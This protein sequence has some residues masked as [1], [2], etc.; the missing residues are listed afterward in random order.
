[1]KTA[2]SGDFVGRRREL[3]A[4]EA[5]YAA[6]SAQLLPVY[7][8]R[9]VGKT[10]LLRRFA[11]GKP[12][13]FFSAAQKLR[14]SQLS[15]FLRA[16]A[17]HLGQSFLAELRTD[18]WETALRAVRGAADRA[19]KLVLV[20]DEF[21][22]LCASAPELPSVLQ[23][24]WD[25]EWQRDPRL[26]LVL[27][28]SA[29]GFMEREVLGA[30]SPLFGRRTGQMRIEPLGFAEAGEMFPRWSLEE[31]ARLWFVVGGVPAYLRQF[32]AAES[33]AQNLARLVF[34]P[35]GFF[36]QEPAFLLRE[37]LTEPSHAFSILQAVGLGRQG[38][39]E[40]ADE[41]G[42]KPNA[43]DRHLKALVALGY[44]ERVQPLQPGE[45]SRKAVQYRV[46]DPLL[47]FWF[48]YVEAHQHEIGRLAPARAFEQIVAPTWEAHCGDGFERLCRDALPAIYAREGVPG[49]FRV[50]DFW[51]RD[52]QIDVV[53]LRTDGVVDLG[54]CKW[55]EHAGLAAAARE[56]AAAAK[57]YPAGKLRVRPLIF[58]RKPARA[59]P[60]AGAK[61][62]SL[63]EICGD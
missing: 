21:Q 51:S 37:E 46:A 16:A 39:K 35:D 14:Q 30:K 56:L 9:R 49:R 22:W 12:A 36:Q 2:S 10:E 34:R 52:V 47:R 18:S 6:R 54:E 31:R 20:L 32:D 33:V 60:P 63:V 17:S 61:V 25:E 13:V 19:R 43:L 59:K 23:R 1:M 62:Y 45:P 28:G 44:M 5:A 48:R 38:Q 29:I 40:V 7:G 11:A 26:M 50:G 53:G 3:A 57:H 8:R 55:G 24:L 4:L 15:D 41:V 27:C 58:L 42:L